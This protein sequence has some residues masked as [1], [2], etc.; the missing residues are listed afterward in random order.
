LA[1]PVTSYAMD[2]IFDS[3]VSDENFDAQLIESRSCKL[4]NVAALLSPETNMTNAGWAG[5]EL[6]EP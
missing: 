1:S 6:M 2:D 5:L 4:S 3:S